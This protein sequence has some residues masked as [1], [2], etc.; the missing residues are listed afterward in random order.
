ME[1]DCL[2]LGDFQTNCYIL[3]A[4]GSATQCV[5]VDTGL[6]SH[7]LVDF[8][9][10]HKLTPTAV[11]L[12]H[13][14]ADHIAGLVGLRRDFPRTKV[15][16]HRLDADMLTNP[17]TNL[18]AMAGC[19]LQLPA[20]DVLI[21]DGDTIE[22][23]GLKLKVF[24]TPGH[25]PGGICLYSQADGVVFVGDTL[26]AGSVGRTDFPGGSMT[27][28]LRSIEQNLLTLPGQTTVYP[29]HGPTTTIGEEQLH[30]AFLRGRKSKN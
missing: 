18:S 6:E 19:S 3:R 7:D 8:L 28:L 14:H 27:Q 23:A 12:T 21:E 17:R 11:V 16:I 22:E 29:G 4:D 2:I 15:Y 20:P 13:G 9:T 10:E 5:L 25:T 24:H 26:F 30:N 1:I